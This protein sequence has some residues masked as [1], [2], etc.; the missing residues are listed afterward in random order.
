MKVQK[1]QVSRHIINDRANRL[2]IIG[3]TVGFGE[4][5][6]RERYSPDKESWSCFMDSGCVLIWSKDKSKLVTGFIPRKEQV[7]WIYGHPINRAI[8]K[9]V[10]NA[11][12]KYFKGLQKA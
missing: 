1:E 9:L 11:Q 4:K 12:T 5:V 7:M 10:S 8:E 6:L 2:A 3:A